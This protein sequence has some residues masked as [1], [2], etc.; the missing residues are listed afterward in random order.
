[1][2]T[3]HVLPHL[4]PSGAARELRLLLTHGD[5]QAHVCCLGDAGPALDGVA[6]PVEALGWRR[7]LDPRPLWA[8]AGRIREWQPD[9]ICAWGLAA[10]RIV[11]LV[12]QRAPVVVRRPLARRGAL[13]RFDRWLLR[14]TDRVLATTEA[15]LTACCCAGV[16][17]HRIQLV[18]PGVVLVAAPPPEV[19]PPA[20]VCLG[21]LE[22]RKGFFEALW[23]FDI[24]Q[25]ADPHVELHLAGDG[26]ER[27]RLE[28][29]AANMDVGQRIRFLGAVADNHALWA[30][31]S[32]VW[33]P[34]LA[35]T[36]AGV[37]LEAMAAGRPVVASRWPGLAEIVSDGE[38]GFL[39]PPGD[40]VAL[41][42]HARVL[43][44]DAALRRRMGE[45]GRR[46]VQQH[47]D[48]ERFV[49][50]WHSAAA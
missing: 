46:R 24:L 14:G 26:P 18:A 50:S 32:V 33:V 27:R 9:S 8:L 35:D 12:N 29:F 45:A 47:F 2:R 48:G 11:R 1:M 41:A 5:A 3:L 31:A 13:S 17:E 23:S 43:L 16:A 6:A 21:A 38:T 39:V 20:I 37:V 10:L 49:R 19:E 25:F 44:Q 40:K 28:Q 4:E 42:R 7:A 34:S 15:E 22:P 30:R 36:G